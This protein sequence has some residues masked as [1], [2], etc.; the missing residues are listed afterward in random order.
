MRVEWFLS[1][2]MFGG[3]T[4]RMVVFQGKPV[5]WDNRPAVSKITGLVLKLPAGELPLP[6]LTLRKGTTRRKSKT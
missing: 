2:V 5:S 6:S 4:G 1:M 3:E